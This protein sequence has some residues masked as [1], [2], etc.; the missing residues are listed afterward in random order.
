[1][2]AFRAVTEG[3]F[4]PSATSCVDFLNDKFSETENPIY[5][6]KEIF[7][8]ALQKKRR[9]AKY[10]N[11]GKVPGSSKFRVMLFSPDGE[12]KAAPYLCTC[13]KT[14]FKKNVSLKKIIEIALFT[15]IAINLFIFE[16]LS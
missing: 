13:K 9:D 7:Q 8:E 12:V 2:T 4:F 15:K 11:Y 1:M 10:T 6:I 14:V 16:I 5:C 3:H